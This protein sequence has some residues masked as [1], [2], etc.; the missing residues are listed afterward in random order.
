MFARRSLTTDHFQFIRIASS[1]LNKM[2]SAIG[3]SITRHAHL[4]LLVCFL[5]VSL[6]IE[7]SIHAQTEFVLSAPQLNRTSRAWLSDQELRVVDQSGQETVYRRWPADD[8]A[9]GLYVA[10]INNA[11]GQVIR[12]PVAHNGAMQIGTRVGGTTQFRASQMQ[13]S[14]VGQLPNGNGRN[15]GLVLPPNAMA[16]QANLNNNL[17]AH[18]VGANNHSD[19]FQNVWQRKEAKPELVRLATL[20]NRNTTQYLSLGPNNRVSLAASALPAQ[21]D[22]FVVPA[23]NGY[24]RIQQQVGNNWN[25]LAANSKSLLVQTVSSSPS[26]L[27]RVIPASNN[28]RGYWLENAVMPGYCLSGSSGSLALLPLGVGP[29]QLWL[30]APAPIA[31]GYEPFWKTVRHDV[32]P[33]PPLPPAQI[34]MVNSH[35]NAIVL[36]ISDRRTTGARQVRIEPASRVT[37]P[38]D[39]DSGSTLIETYEIRSPSGLW[40]QQRFVTQIPAAPIYDVSVYEE[41]L[42]SIAIDRTGTS[43][44]PIED[45]NYQ[46][47]SVGWLPIPAGEGLPARGQF[48]AFAEAK[49]ANNPGAVR[50]FDPKSLEKKS[51]QPDPLESRLNEFAPKLPNPATPPAPRQ[52]F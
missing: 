29:S 23:S 39:R 38:F 8:S 28:M 44:N 17:Q 25:A 10:Y 26:Q 11:A 4:S 35:N 5:F 22:W 14:P 42:Q 19:L 21:S 45:V 47:K 32:Q 16:N 34:D 7:Q 52:K 27:W 31:V 40:D 48:D 9:D 20:D 50:R 6:G 13:V 41:F 2:Y 3:R 36:L 12:W 30:P 33:N 1:G 46:P 24:V 43:P 18:G 51:T 49:A 37:I 15:N